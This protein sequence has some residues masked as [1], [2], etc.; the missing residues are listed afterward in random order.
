MRYG[1]RWWLSSSRPC[2]ATVDPR[3]R[4]LH[5][6]MVLTS[7]P[8]IRTRGLTVSSPDRP[9]AADDL[10]LDI[11]RAPRLIGRSSCVGQRTDCPGERRVAQSYST[12]FDFLSITAL[13]EAAGAQFD[14]VL[15]CQPRGADYGADGLTRMTLNG[16]GYLIGWC[17]GDDSNHDVVTGSWTPPNLVAAVE[18]GASS[19]ALLQTLAAREAD[20]RRFDAELAQFKEASPAAALRIPGRGRTRRNK[21]QR[22]EERRRMLQHRPNCRRRGDYR[23]DPCYLT[24]SMRCSY[25]VPAHMTYGFAVSGFASRG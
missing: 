25:G 13:L 2:S 21:R 19:P 24:G 14:G 22:S 12:L 1:R 10:G 6:G 16:R 11:N 5:R 4:A 3:P 17:E 23:R 18:A 15:S 7:C 20:L 8:V 9:V